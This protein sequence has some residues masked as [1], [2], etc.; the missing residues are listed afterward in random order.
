MSDLDTLWV[1][2]GI[3]LIIF[4]AWRKASAKSPVAD[5]EF[6]WTFNKWYFGLMALVLIYMLI[7]FD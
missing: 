7:T 2:G 3:A 5:T 4:I 1:L 6:G